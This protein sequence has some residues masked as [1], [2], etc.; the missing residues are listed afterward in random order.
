V[1]LDNSFLVPASKAVAWETLLDVPSM[2]SCMPGAELVGQTGE[3][4]WKVNMK[5]KFG[6]IGLNF[7]TDVTQEEADEAAG[8]VLLK[9]KARETK[10]RGGAQA[11][12]VSTLTEVDEGTR[13]D[14]S[15]DVLLSGPV[16]QYGRG[17]V[18]DVSNEMV[19]QFAEN[20]RAQ[21][22]TGEAAAAAPA[23]PA[24]ASGD[25]APAA[26][27][28]GASMASP[29][30]AGA[31]AG[32]APAAAPPR[33]APAPVKPVSGFKIGLKVLRAM[34]ARLFRRGG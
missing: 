5:V 9:A 27:A 30:E 17:L 16:A 24:A 2:V 26:S 19:G 32:S 28:N 14:I 10:G 33:P 8:R 4:A 3:N 12:I 7:A 13:V 20:M 1:K 23:E 15:T 21:I 18:Q 6:P 22:G 34:I 31:P 25:G 29:V 11:T